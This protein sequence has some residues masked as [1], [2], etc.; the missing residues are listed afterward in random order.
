[1]KSPSMDSDKKRAAHVKRL[2]QGSLDGY[3][4]IVHIQPDGTITHFDSLNTLP[5]EEWKNCF[6]ATFGEESYCQ[7]DH[8]AGRPGAGVVFV[9]ISASNPGPSKPRNE[10]ASLILG[11]T[12]RGDAFVYGGSWAPASLEKIGARRE[13]VD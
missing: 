11:E 6:E 2:V 3:Q 8:Y 13:D 4:H 10:I 7:R 12:V 9:V 1:M 5:Q